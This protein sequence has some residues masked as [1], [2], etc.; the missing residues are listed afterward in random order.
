MFEKPL[1]DK[2]RAF[3]GKLLS[4]PGQRQATDKKF[5]TVHSLSE[6]QG[7][8][9]KPQNSKDLPYPMSK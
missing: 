7:H 4:R 3:G 1:Y 6:R 9:G 5:C 2:A 8:L